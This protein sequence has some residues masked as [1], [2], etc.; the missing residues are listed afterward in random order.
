MRNVLTTIAGLLALAAVFSA[1]PVVADHD[2]GK[3]QGN[4]F[5]HDKNKGAF[6]AWTPFGDAERVSIGQGDFAYALTSV[7]APD[8]MIFSFG[9]V[10]ITPK[11]TLTFAD[12]KQLSAD[13][14]LIDGA[15][16]GSPRFQVT[17]LTED[18]PKNV[19]VYIGTLPNFT[20]APSEPGEWESTGNLIEATDLR[21]DTTQ[22]GGT[23]YDDYEGALLLAGNLEVVEVSLV[24]DG[25]F[26]F[27]DGVQTVL[28]DNVRVNNAV[29]SANGN[30][31]K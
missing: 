16:G 19:F 5:G 4:A 24:V 23:F 7:Y 13:Y 17:V 27:A 30:S 11:K 28:V 20:D 25:G 3:G 9:G 18:G 8:E 1:A 29:L 12:I 21:F 10:A 22:L 26:A 31:K 15:G 2:N 14:Q 6:G